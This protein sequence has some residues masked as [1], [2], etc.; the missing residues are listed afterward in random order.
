MNAISDIRTGEGLTRA[1]AEQ[2]RAL[3]WDDIPD[4]A[5]TWARQCILDY[6]GCG[7]AGASDPLVDLLLAEMREQGGVETAS[8]LGLKGKLPPASAALVNGAASH[9]LDFDDVN[10]AMPGH[11]S[12]AILPGLLAL[13]EER[14]ASGRDVLT[15]FVAGYELQ[16]RVGRVIS[17]GH[18]DKLG[19]HATATVGSFG[20]AAACAHLLGL[21]ADAFARALGIAGT[22]AAGLKS[23]FGTMCKPLHAGKAS[24]HGLLAAKLAGRGFTARTD[25]IECGQGFARTHSPDFNPERAFDTPPGGWFVMNNLFKYH[26][27]CYMTHAAIDAAR[28]LRETHRFQPQDIEAIDV[29]LEEACDRICNIPAPVTGL[30]AKFSLRLTTAMGLAGVDTSRL[31]S[32]S[33][34]VAADPVL[35][36]LRDKVSLDFRTGIPNTFTEITL[37]LRDGQSVTAQHDA[38]IPAADA[39]KQG[40]RLEQKF[41][42]L[43]DPVLGADNAAALIAAVRGFEGLPDVRGL[44]GRAAS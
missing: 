17:P 39:A 5:R 30:E 7:I 9:A 35:V 6:L 14:G 21:D 27:S 36:G 19:F 25:V 12:V 34:K 23:M 4:T 33:E 26:A 44:M 42:A 15:A 32:Y 38:G 1:L 41:T 31:A 22:Q 13:A 29:R 2:A 40:Q 11:P 10:L 3:R 18:Y 28:T 20:A 37:K 43:V 8:L 24:Y 16:C